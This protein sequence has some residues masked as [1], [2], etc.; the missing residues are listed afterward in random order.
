MKGWKPKICGVQDVMAAGIEGSHMTN[1]TC[2]QQVQGLRGY[3]LPSCFLVSAAY[4]VSHLQRTAAFVLFISSPGTCLSGSL[5]N[6]ALRASRQATKL[7]TAHLVLV[8]VFL[9]TNFFPNASSRV[10]STK[11]QRFSLSLSTAFSLNCLRLCA[12]SSFNF[13]FN[14]ASRF[15]LPQ[16]KPFVCLPQPFLRDVC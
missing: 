3:R 8:K 4:K 12:L 16:A 7:D 11:C 13:F 5:P 2:Q 15:S 6:R 1:N 9:H 10:S 14:G